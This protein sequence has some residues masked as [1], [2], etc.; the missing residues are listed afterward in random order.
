MQEPLAITRGQLLAWGWDGMTGLG[1]QVAEKRWERR[2]EV[3]WGSQLSPYD[4]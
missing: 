1:N 3:D 4:F 2:Q